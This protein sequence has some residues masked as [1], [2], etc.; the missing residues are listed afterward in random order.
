MYTL[1]AS[2]PVGVT[3]VWTRP[4]EMYEMCYYCVPNLCCIIDA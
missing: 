2:E 1:P 4:E 3:P